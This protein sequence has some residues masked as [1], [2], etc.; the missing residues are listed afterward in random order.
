[1][2][3]VNIESPY[4]GDVAANTAYAL[5]C[6][7]DSLARGE[8]PFAMHLL[9]TQVLDDTVPEE[10]AK[11]IAAGLAWASAA[12]L[13]AVYTDRGISAGM[14]QGILAAQCR[15]IRITYRC[16]HRTTDYHAYQP[17]PTCVTREV[18]K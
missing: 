4:A 11:G 6:M 17:C 5:G 15:G 16:R 9:Y 1:M 13:C 10:R 8:A 2:I 12:E 18:T 14:R 7:R 3:R